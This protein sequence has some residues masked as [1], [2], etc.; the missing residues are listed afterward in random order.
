[1]WT[2]DEPWEAPIKLSGVRT[3]YELVRAAEQEYGQLLAP[4]RLLRP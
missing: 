3:M 4:A 1:M 2:H